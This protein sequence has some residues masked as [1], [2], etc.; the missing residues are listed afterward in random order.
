MN[1]ENFKTK[2]FYFC[3]TFVN[4]INIV[5][6]NPISYNDNFKRMFNLDYM[7]DINEHTNDNQIIGKL[8]LIFNLF[9]ANDNGEKKIQLDFDITGVFLADESIPADEF[10]RFLEHNGIAN[11]YGIAR[12]QIRTISS[13]VLN[14]EIINLPLINVIEFVKAKKNKKL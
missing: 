7:I 8:T 13:L 4:K 2:G 1:V 12:A 3:D 5:C 10:I 6:D 11:V 14:T 9:A